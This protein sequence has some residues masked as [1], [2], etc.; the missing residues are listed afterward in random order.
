[1]KF[2]RYRR[3][4]PSDGW[5]VPEDVPVT[6]MQNAAFAV[7]SMHAEGRPTPLT[8]EELVAILTTMREY[9]PSASTYLDGE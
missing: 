3:V 5:R 6:I 1:M 9:A 2:T 4:S 8:E 7:V